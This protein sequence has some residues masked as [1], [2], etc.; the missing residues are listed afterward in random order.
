MFTEEYT[1]ACERDMSSSVID[2]RSLIAVVQNTIIV[3]CERISEK[4][5]YGGC[6]A[7]MNLR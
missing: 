3:I 2:S 4:G 1:R 7:R 6:M 5:P